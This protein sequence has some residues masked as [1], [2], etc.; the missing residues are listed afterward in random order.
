[1]KV[2]IER[3]YEQK[4][5]KVVLKMVNHASFETCHSS[6]YG[7]EIKCEGH[8]LNGKQLYM[9]SQSKR[10]IKTMKF[11]KSRVWFFI[12]GKKAFDNLEEFE[13]FYNIKFIDN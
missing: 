3:N 13:E 2:N 11:G 10:S 7:G 8:I 9:K 12:Q 6:L 5:A 1:M 4:E